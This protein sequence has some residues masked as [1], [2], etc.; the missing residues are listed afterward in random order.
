MFLRFFLRPR[1]RKASEQ[2]KQCSRKFKDE[3]K[4]KKIVSRWVLAENENG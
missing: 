1:R 3:E 4:D 2:E